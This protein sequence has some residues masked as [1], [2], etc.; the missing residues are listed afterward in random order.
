MT[1]TRWPGT[2]GLTVP[3]TGTVLMICALPPRRWPTWIF[4]VALSRALRRGAFV[5]AAAAAARRGRAGER[6]SDQRG[7]D[8]ALHG[9]DATEPSRATE[10]FSMWSRMQGTIEP[11][12]S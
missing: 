4:T 5:A 11:V 7:Q 2:N 6:R 1:S 10:L 3:V 12:L 9:G 8:E